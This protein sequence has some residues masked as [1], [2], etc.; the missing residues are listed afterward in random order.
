MTKAIV[1][2]GSMGGLLAAR[3]LA[4]FFDE[5][6]IV[7]RDRFP[8]P[9]EHRRGAPQGRHTHGLLA[10]GANVLEELLPGLRQDLLDAGAVS[11]DV[12]SK[13]RW[14]HNGG[15]LARVESGLDALAVSRPLLEGLVRRRV[16]AYRGIQTLEECAATGLI[17]TP[18]GKRI[19]GLRLQ[20]GRELAADLVVNAAGRASQG[21]EWLGSLGY[22]KPK[23]ERVEIAL[24][25]TTRHFRRDPADLNGDIVA[26]IPPTPT[27][28]RGGVIA[29]QEGDRWTVTLTSHFGHSAPMDIDGFREY[30]RTLPSPDI[31]EAIRNAEPVDEPQTARF[32]ASV[33]HRYESLDRFPI[34]YLVF[35]D[36][37]C[38][39]NPIYGQG[40]SV[41]A[42]QAMALRQSL[43]RYAPAQWAKAFFS[44]AAKVVDI[45]WSIVVGN[46][47]RMPEATGQ[48]TAGMK[49]V[50]WYIASLHRAAHRD[51][52]LSLAFHRVANLLKPPSSLMHPHLVWRVAKVLVSAMFQLHQRRVERRSAAH[53]SQPL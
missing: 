31:Y 49:F 44:A 39:F 48:R 52:V 41:A 11:G 9:G 19:T 37:I 16:L 22:P 43:K 32:P 25:Y 29:A 3:V 7:E 10:A 4:D 23:Q 6:T 26:V 15:H 14:F 18:D 27:G 53:V 47:L 12:A 20:D 8:D 13:A 50:N 33:R 28:K 36:A 42:L 2:G 46:D 1:V 17:A 51:A 30:A 34:G 40:M 5:V 24:G 45:P 21:R 38:S 35:G